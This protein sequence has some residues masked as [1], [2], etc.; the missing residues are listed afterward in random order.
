MT[1]RE[2]V[3]R[4]IADGFRLVFWP[5]KEDWKGPREPGWIDHHYT[6][7]DYHEG[8]RVG[9]MHGVEM[10]TGTGRYVVDV[11]VDWAPGVEIAKAMLPA[12]GFVWGRPSKRV[13]HC[14]YTTPDLVPMQV[15]KDISKDG[16]DGITF[17]EFRSDKH[18]AMAPP[19]IHQKNGTR[20]P[21]QFVFA[22]EPTFID[23]C[24]KLKQ[25]TCLAAIG[26][27]LAHHFGMNGFGHE[28]RLAWA[29][30]LLRAGIDLEDLVTMGTAISKLC[31]NTEVADVRRV[32]ESTAANL[33]HDGKKVKGG[34]ALARVLGSN[35][36]AVVKRI[37]E[38]IGRDSDF[39]RVE[40][41]IVKDSQQ[42]IRVAIEALGRALSYNAF[43]DKMLIA[44]VDEQG[45]VG[46]VQPLE[47]R[48]LNETWL[49]I[50]EEYRFRPTFAFFE[51]VIYRM[52][53]DNPF[54]P[55]KDYLDALRW[56]KVQRVDE[57]LI[58]SANVEDTPYVRA[59]SA[60]ML[61]AAVRR[62]YSPGAKYDELVVLESGQGL[63]KSTA[64]RALCPRS[65]WFSDD[66]PLN[67]TSQKMIE[68][69]LGKWIIEAGELAGR[70]KTEIEHLKAT[71]SRQVDGPARL[72]YA[73]MPV[74]RPRH[75]II[76]GTTNSP[77]YINDPT[78]ARRFWPI[79]V[80]RFD[81]DYIVA[82]RDQLW[83][84]A[85]A[86]H[87]AD[88]S[89]RLH[90]SLW[91]EAARQQE[92]RREIDPWEGIIR[93][94]LLELQP[95]SDDKRRVSVEQ[96][97]AALSIPVERRDRMGAMRIAEIMHRLGFKRTTV[98]NGDIIQGGYV[99]EDPRLLEHLEDARTPGE[100]DGDG[101]LLMPAA[102]SAKAD[103]EPPPF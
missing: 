52:A 38:W 37:N 41:K 85:V 36:K 101:D 79:K 47:D 70:K 89:I 78:G 23:G 46:R 74:E 48:Q 99:T 91:P 53:W 1:G 100:D 57:W 88:A 13:S 40:G 82:V 16:K 11:D 80:N 26:M 67:T 8:D 63:N 103:D 87:R 14:L 7:D 59:V 66:L 43:A 98:R 49:R 31:N 9:I 32:L 56:D 2:Q 77:V 29:G 102:P 50:D 19:S 92:R 44:D 35:G 27:I 60:I 51:K 15:Y 71:L 62:I 96:V 22:K 76:V 84:E 45:N 21:L 34:P 55:V 17:I 75:F 93:Q 39:V 30:F 68:S 65:E 42:N 72:A 69:T 33:A 12:T 54:H 64:L 58:R 5:D 86:R 83:A 73:R 90:E 3:Q 18:Q 94:M 6:I 81:V 95:A 61:T 4:F 97:W 20:E 24:A 28:A 25:R 10:A